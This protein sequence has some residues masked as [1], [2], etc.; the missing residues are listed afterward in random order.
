L[1]RKQ[2][3]ALIDGRFLLGAERTSIQASALDLHLS[4]EAFILNKGSVKPTEPSH[5]E[6]LRQRGLVTSL[7]P[8][9]D[10]SYLLQAHRT[11]LFKL[12]ER[13]DRV[14]DLGEC[15][16]YGQATAKSSVGRVDVLARLI[17]DG[18]SGYEGFVPEDLSHSNGE[19]F[20][21]ITPI[22]FS[23]LVKP[24][25]SLSQLR[26]FYGRPED[27]EIRSI[28]LWN[29]VLKERDPNSREGSLSVDLTNRLIADIPAAAFC[30]DVGQGAEAE[31]PLWTEGGSNKPDPCAYWD[32]VAADPDGR[33]QI[34]TNKFYILRSKE[35][36]AMP[37]SVAVYCRAIDETIGEMRIH[38]AGFVHPC[39]GLHR[40]DGVVGTP[41]I[42]EVR[43]HDLDVNLGQGEIMARLS[44]YRMSEEADEEGDVSTYDTQE[45]QLSK[46]FASWPPRLERRP[47]GTLRPSDAHAA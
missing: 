19:L 31:V 22:T 28:Q 27:S 5:L 47:N 6:F 17:V 39:F 41:L 14:R 20:L 16:M 3:G 21:E 32:I 10:G 18:M 23:V 33:L 44:F 9:A 8:R 37:R 13:L 38:Y 1:G 29:T 25:I 40:A 46:F 30:A 42:F 26:F 34:Q 11:Y 7:E 2:L 36:I 15:G 35:R 12:R 4:N 43:G 45:L 24:G